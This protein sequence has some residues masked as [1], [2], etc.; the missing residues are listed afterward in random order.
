MAITYK[1][2]TDAEKDEEKV[3]TILEEFTDQAYYRP[4]YTLA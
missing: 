3:V 2:K 1:I 4:L